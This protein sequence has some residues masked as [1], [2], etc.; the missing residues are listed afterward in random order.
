MI[1][2]CHTA[3]SIARVLPLLFIICTFAGCSNSDEKFALVS[4]DSSTILKQVSIHKEHEAVLINFWAT[5]CSPC[6]DEFPIVVDLSNE[7]RSKGLATYFISVDWDDATEQVIQFL[8]EQGVGGISFI[9]AGKDGPFIN[10]I[11]TEWTGAVPFTVVF[12]R[13][14]GEI[15]ALWEGEADREIFEAA[16]HAALDQ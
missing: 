10:G 16:I 15:V 14:S 7:Y 13:Q 5:W 8:Q 11:S 1:N 12:G 4:A 9:K 2:K 6:V 3:T